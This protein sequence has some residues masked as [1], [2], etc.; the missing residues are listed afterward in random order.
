MSFCF[1]QMICFLSF[2]LIHCRLASADGLNPMD[3]FKNTSDCQ[4]KHKYIQ[5]CK[6][7]K[8]F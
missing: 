2:L 7:T 4:Y 5:Y 1:L 8:T 3:V 6:S